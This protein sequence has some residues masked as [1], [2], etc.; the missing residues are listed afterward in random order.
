M[1]Q[2]Q[3]GEGLTKAQ[4]EE[5]EAMIVGGLQGDAAKRG[6]KLFKDNMTENSIEFKGLGTLH[7]DGRA[8]DYAPQ[9]T[10]LMFSSRPQHVQ[11]E[12]TNREFGYFSQNRVPA[13]LIGDTFKEVRKGTD[14]FNQTL[15]KDQVS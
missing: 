9:D 11:N 14:Q 1:R 6:K 5:L 7:K 15:M 8:M 3:I 12:D 10:R 2:L 13:N 4:Q